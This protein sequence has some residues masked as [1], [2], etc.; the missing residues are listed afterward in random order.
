[1]RSQTLLSETMITSYRSLGLL[2]IASFLAFSTF[3]QSC[4]ILAVEKDTQSRQVQGPNSQPRQTA[5]GNRIQAPKANDSAATSRTFGDFDLPLRATTRQENS[6]RNNADDHG[7]DAVELETINSEPIQQASFKGSY[8]NNCGPVCDCGECVTEIVCGIEQPRGFFEE[9]GCGIESLFSR[10][11][12]CDGGCDGGC[13]ECDG[14]IYQTNEIYVEGD[15]CG[16]E[17]FGDCGCDTCSPCDSEPTLLPLIRFNWCRYEFFAGVQ[18]HTGPLNH[19]AINNQNSGTQIGSGSFGFYE[20]FNRGKSMNRLLGLDIA[21]QLGVRGTQNNLSGT[22]FTTDTRHQVFITAGFFRRVDYGVQYGLVLDYMN[23]DW[24]F[25]SNSLQLRGELSWRARECDT[26][27]F[28]F[29][30][31]VR[32]ETISATITDQSGS[33]LSEDLGV[34][35]TD[36]FR[37]FYRRPLARN[38]E[39]DLMVGWTDNKDGLL[40]ASF[41]L[42]LTHQCSL[43][44]GATY[45]IPHEGTNSGGFAEEN[46][47]VSLGLVY[48]PGGPRGCGRYCRPL[49]DVADNGT[50]MLDFE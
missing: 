49:F 24:Y 37:F 26:Y 36:Q 5:A 48:R 20:G 19:I 15:G 23:Q 27:G 42:P 11:R 43:S 14:V 16:M 33:A 32:E 21:T 29:M 38:G 50:F 3:L 44:S 2:R 8:A 7:L 40:G 31:G 4:S 12:G 17:V 41:N 35:P 30:A 1:M 13:G 45:L 6:S 10:C 28:Q 9:V 39:Y 22:A 25:Q 34:K 47:N 18:G 46:W